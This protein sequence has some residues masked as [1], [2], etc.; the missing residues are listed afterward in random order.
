VCVSG[1]AGVVEVVNANNLVV[2]FD[3][4]GEEGRFTA[5]VAKD[6]VTKIQ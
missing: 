4:G 2:Q 1:C 3:L 6:Q 5:Y